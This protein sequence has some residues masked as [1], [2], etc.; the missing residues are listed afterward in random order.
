MDGSTFISSV[1]L[2]LCKGQHDKDLFSA[3]V[4]VTKSLFT[5]EDCIS[6][7]CPKFI[8]LVTSRLYLHLSHSCLFVCL[9][10]KSNYTRLQ[11]VLCASLSAYITELPIRLSKKENLLKEKQTSIL[12]GYP[13]W[14]YT[15]PLL[16]QVLSSYVPCALSFIPTHRYC[17]NIDHRTPKRLTKPEIETE[18]TF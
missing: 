14:Y 6:I 9:F 2:W 1:D 5:M 4:V 12:P 13:L 7:R 3:L 8:F 16:F 10:V 11:D 15:I 18:G 17:W